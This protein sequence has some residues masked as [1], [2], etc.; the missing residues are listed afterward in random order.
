MVVDNFHPRGELGAR[1][2]GDFNGRL[3]MS[4]GITTEKKKV[5]VGG[6][7]GCRKFCLRIRGSIHYS[8]SH[9]DVDVGF[10][11]ARR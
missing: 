6:D 7:F 8:P 2:E 4:Q 9:T 3:P 1:P 10:R 11:C 5:I